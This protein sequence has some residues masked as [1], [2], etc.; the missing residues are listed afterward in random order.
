MHLVNRARAG[1]SIPHKL[2]PDLVPPSTRYLSDT[3]SQVK[4]ALVQD[5]MFQ[6][7]VGDHYV[8]RPKSVNHERRTE[9]WDNIYRAPR[10]GDVPKVSDW[11]PLDDDYGGGYRSG[12]RRRVPPPAVKAD[13]WSDLRGTSAKYAPE[14]PPVRSSTSSYKSGA[15]DELIRRWRKELGEQRV[16]LEAA[17]YEAGDSTIAYAT[18]DELKARVQMERIKDKIRDLEDKITRAERGEDV[19]KE[20]R[21]E[22]LTIEGPSSTEISSSLPRPS[23][24]KP[25]PKYNLEEEEEVEEVSA[26]VDPD[27]IKRIAAERIAQRMSAL[28]GKT[29]LPPPPP[30]VKLPINTTPVATTKSEPSTSD[31][32]AKANTKEERQRII[33]EEAERRIKEREKFLKQ[34][35]GA[36][37][38]IRSEP[39]PPTVAAPPPPPAVAPSPP[40]VTAVA[41]VKEPE[42]EPAPVPEYI[43]S[44]GNVKNLAASL[45]PQGFPAAAPAPVP[46]TAVTSTTT[47]TAATV[48]AKVL[49]SFQANAAD[50]IDLNEGETI[51]I[52]P[53]KTDSTGEWLFGKKTN[54]QQGWFPKAYVQL[55]T[56]GEAAPIQAAPA[57]V[58]STVQ[59]VHALYDYQAQQADELSF[60][61]GESFNVL[62]QL[63]ADWA[64]ARNKEGKQGV[65]PLAYVEFDQ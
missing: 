52:V 32:L 18:E 43:P 54:G 4:T 31:L 56:A 25:A 63:D 28:T 53:G 61:Q 59:A 1:Q 17:S 39:V 9:E 24:T 65:I 51:A 45:F 11:E 42:P 64:M 15:M 46:S 6:R 33:M 21:K 44:S 10:F 19:A 8:Q 38:S 26:A 27:K 60:R 16:L 55:V 29:T 35:G 7:Q 62:E 34:T 36:T 49:F 14:T 58:A 13:P 22:Q 40:I 2:T 57:K 3:V 50:D 12:N 30:E 37:L 41:P 20:A 47:S 48:M 23:V 5:I